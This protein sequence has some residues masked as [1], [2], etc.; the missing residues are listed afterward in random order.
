MSG[1]FAGFQIAGGTR[2]FL[3]TYA[4][5]GDADEIE[6]ANAILASCEA[7]LAT[8][9][10]WFSCDYD[11][12]PYGIWVQV[13][14]GSPGAGADNYGYT[15]SESPIIQISGT[16]PQQGVYVLAGAVAQMLFV[17]ELAEILM[18]FTSYGW[19]AGNNAARGCPGSRPPSCTAPGP[20]RRR[21]ACARR[22][23]TPGSTPTRD[24]TG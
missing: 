16:A 23:R 19:N 11:T 24:R 18:G 15:T 8:L 2:H 20:T 4:D 1:T 21:S 14:K 7:D 3:I 9:E 5:A 13:L 12:A 6:R 10:Q 17:A 22:G